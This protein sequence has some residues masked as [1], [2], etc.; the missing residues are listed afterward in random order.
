MW[1]HWG[2]AVAYTHVLPCDLT[3]LC[4]AAPGVFMMGLVTVLRLTFGPK[5]TVHAT[6]CIDTLIT[7]RF[8]FAWRHWSS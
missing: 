7:C 1:G 3:S 5:H 8:R 6:S 2:V 4:D